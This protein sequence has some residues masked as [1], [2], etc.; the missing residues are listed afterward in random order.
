MIEMVEKISWMFED[1]IFDAQ[2]LTICKRKNDSKSPGTRKS[3]S[4]IPRWASEVKDE[5]FYIRVE[6][7]PKKS[8]A[9]QPVKTL[10]QYFDQP[11]KF[12]L[13][14]LPGSLFGR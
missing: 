9:L 8:S 3:D 5:N 11:R 7:D 12:G 13:I 4:Y 1:E 10:K 14:Q 6:L 2:C